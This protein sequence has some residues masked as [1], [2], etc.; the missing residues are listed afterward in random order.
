[1]NETFLKLRKLKGINLEKFLI[2]INYFSLIILIYVI[3]RLLFIAFFLNSYELLFTDERI[4]INDIYNV[5][6]L[7][8]EF[9]RYGN[10]D[11]QVLKNVLLVI[12]EIVYGGDLRYGRIWSNIFIFLLGPLSLINDQV[13]VT[14]VRI[15]TI[16]IYFISINLLINLFLDKNLK[17]F[18]LLVFYCIPGAF[19]FNI[20]PKPDPF[21]ILFVALALL[22]IKK[23]NFNWALFLLGVATGVKIVGIF[24]LALIVMYLLL[25]NKIKVKISSFFKIL[26]IPWCGLVFANPI[27]LI[28]P[29]N[30]GSLPNFYK[31]Y[32]NWINSQSLYGQEERF[33]IKHL[34]LWSDSISLQFSFNLLKNSI[35]TFFLMTIVLYAAFQLAKNKQ[36]LILTIMTIGISHLL[37]IFLSVERQWLMYLNFSF[38]FIFIRLIFFITNTS[39]RKYLLIIF[40]FFTVIPTGIYNLNDSFSTKNLD[41]TTDIQDIELVINKINNLYK[42]KSNSFNIV[43]WD[44]QY[45]MARNNV[46]HI[47]SFEIKEHWEY[48]NLND[49]LQK[50]DF[51]V[52]KV[53]IPN[54][55][56]DIDI[57]G[58]YFIYYRNN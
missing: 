40:L 38:I 2:Y 53:S 11:N 18:Y 49:T 27:L 42:L 56:F 22:S 45:G 33:N 32:Y 7:D 35:F 58:E 24:A 10:V 25:T 55:D 1:M 41:D 46:T 8:N 21:V 51:Y 15:F 4:I 57:A 37:F 36:Y 9:D 48:N 31:I 6:N 26:I 5:W 14:S 23:E 20:V 50:S 28:P 17:W 19:Y 47:G 52:T 39:K 54:N 34:T 16:F 12:T 13:L 43:Y 29:L 3:L 30:I 44:P